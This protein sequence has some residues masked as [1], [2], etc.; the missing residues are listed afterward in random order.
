MVAG[1]F[2]KACNPLEDSYSKC[3]RDS[4]I[5]KD[6]EELKREKTL[7]H[8]SKFSPLVHDCDHMEEKR[9]SHVEFIYIHKVCIK[10]KC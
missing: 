10:M 5:A 7:P 6:C 9:Y 2:A 8:G 4:H 1:H 3:G